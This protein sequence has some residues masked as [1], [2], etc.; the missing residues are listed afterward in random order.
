M[1]FDER[2]QDEKN[3]IEFGGRSAGPIYGGLC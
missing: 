3:S 1:L 2:Q